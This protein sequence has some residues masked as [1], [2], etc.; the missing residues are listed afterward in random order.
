MG[1]W[2]IVV[3]LAAPL[4]G[5]MSIANFVPKDPPQQDKHCRVYGGVRNTVEFIG[6]PG[7]SCDM[8]AH[9]I[10]T[11][12]LLF[13]LPLTLALDTA[14]VPFTL[15][16]QLFVSREAPPEKAPPSPAEPADDRM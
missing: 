8:G 13:D 6:G 11:C 4:S 9:E 2:V 16:A 5:C 10:A 12:L 14:T 7:S 15:L 1:R 3:L